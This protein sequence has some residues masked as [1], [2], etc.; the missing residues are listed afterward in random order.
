MKS[1][2]GV[3]LFAAKVLEGL[4]PIIRYLGV[5]LLGAFGAAPV[6]KDYCP[7]LAEDLQ[8]RADD[9]KGNDDHLAL[10]EVFIRP[11]R[12]ETDSRLEYKTAYEG[13]V[14]NE[15]ERCFDEI[16]NLFHMYQDAHRSD[17]TGRKTQEVLR[18]IPVIGA[19]VLNL[20]DCNFFWF[21]DIL[22]VV[23]LVFKNGGT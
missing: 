19:K 7:L 9:L 17:I 21:A 13:M 14:Y 22:T 1:L 20:R 2:N 10:P 12:E 5:G 6:S 23:L 16:S 18:K 4:A 15:R 8:T 11:F 3:H